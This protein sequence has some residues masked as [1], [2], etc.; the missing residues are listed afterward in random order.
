MPQRTEWAALAAIFAALVGVAVTWLTLDGSPPVWDYANHLERAIRCST[1][2]AAGDFESIFLRSSL[3]PP[4]VLCTAGLAYLVAPSDVGAAQTVILGFLALGM[5]ATYWLGRHFFGGPAGVVAALLFGSAP[6]I[7]H[8]SV[9]FQLDLP[10]AAMVAATLGLLV[11]TEYFAQRSWSV[12]AG[13]VLALGMLTK[14]AYVAYVIPA[15]AIV[16]AGARTHRAIGNAAL[17]GGLG[18]AVSLPWYGPRLLGIVPQILTQAGRRG[19]QEGDPDPFT[20][21]GLAWYPATFPTQFGWLAAAL[22]C[23]GL[24]SAV[25]RRQ[26]LLVASVLAP[27]ALFVT[28]RNKDLRYVL[29]LLPV[30]AVIAGAGFAAVAPRA[31]RAAAVAL[32]VACAFQVSASAFGVP[33]GWRL[34]ILGAPLGVASPPAAADWRQREILSLIVRDAAG[35]PHTISVVPNHPLFSIS[36]FRYYGLR[37]GL[38]LEFVRAWADE[39][40]GID[41]MILKTGALGPEWTVDRPL[42]IAERLDR[43]PHLARVFPVLAE[44]P[45]PDG[46]IATVR[47]RRITD[48][49]VPVERLAEAIEAAVRRRLEDFTRDVDNLRVRLT[50]DGEIRRGRVKRV[51]VTAAA[52]TVGELQRPDTAVLRLRDVGVAF[53]DVLINPYSA[54]QDKRF[55]PLDVGR[56]RLERA[57]I[58]EEDLTAFLS[59]LRRQRG[60]SARLEEGA[61][62]IRLT[63]PGPDVAARVRL[64]TDSDGHFTFVAEQV[65]LGGLPVPDLVAAWVTRH[66]DP[67]PRLRTRLPLELTISPVTITPQALR[68]GAP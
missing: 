7:V 44:L 30:A 52:A 51:E 28:A 1:D 68:I 29:P 49:D 45:L 22:F 23:V 65:R 53:E 19:V 47:G 37:G 26:W 32:V 42:K 61:V 18:V 41:Y 46:S 64:P 15:L 55:A 14:P 40:L 21:A 63:L 60:T 2:L 10:L 59:G 6:F 43:D 62:A 67:G 24:V 66:F 33:A 57:T 48:L 31:R 8:L 54:W 11:R 27:F 34:P 3:Y 9:R 20:L 13:L 36:N 5:A 56:M 17:A 16:A 12:A 25:R 35:A 38:P 58:T 4:L 39:P 50:Y